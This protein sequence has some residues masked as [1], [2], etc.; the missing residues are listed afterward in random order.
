MAGKILRSSRGLT[1]ALQHQIRSHNQLLYRELLQT[2][3]ITVTAETTY[4]M[5]VGFAEVDLQQVWEAGGM[6]SQKRMALSFGKKDV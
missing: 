3:K 2:E 5:I 6:K 1:L 4:G